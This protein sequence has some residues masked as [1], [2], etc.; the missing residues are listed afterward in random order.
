M[1]L[2]VINSQNQKVYLN[3]TAPTRRALINQIGGQNFFLGD[4]L[5]S[6]YDVR[7]E[8]DSNNTATGAVVG[9]VVG[10]LGGPLGILIGGL[11]GGLIGNNSDDEE[12]ILI[13]RFNNS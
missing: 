2:Y 1:K 4:N 5:Y 3:L 11:L 6:V 13:S 12:N 9:G 10:V 7:A 8:N